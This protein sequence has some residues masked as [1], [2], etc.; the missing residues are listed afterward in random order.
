[1]IS[2][3]ETAELAVWADDMLSGGFAS[4]IGGRFCGLP[5][6]CASFLQFRPPMKLHVNGS[7]VHHGVTW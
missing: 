4:G 5:C 2:A 1:L 6:R 3:P 7:S